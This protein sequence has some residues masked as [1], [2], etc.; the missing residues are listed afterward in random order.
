[1]SDTTAG[2][3][4]PESAAPEEDPGAGAQDRISAGVMTLYGLPAV[5]AGYMFMLISLYFLKYAT[6]VL[7]ISPAAMG[8]IF[9]VGRI[10]D[11][12]TDPVAGYL[13]DRTKTRFGRRRPWIVASALP[14]GGAF[15]LLW[16]PPPGELSETWRVLWV[17]GAVL[18]FY[19]GMTSF[20]VPHNSL[21]A[22]LSTSYH[23][24]T[25]VFGV[26]QIAWQIG[27]FV[28]LGL[29]YWLTTSDDPS[30]LASQ[31]AVTS[32]LVMVGLVVVMAVRMRERPEFQ[33]RGGENPFRAFRDVWRN[34]H[35]RLLL[36]V[37]FIES[38][39]GAVIGVLTIYF[40]EYVVETPTYTTA[41]IGA[42]F[43]ALTLAIPVWAPLSQRF[44][45]RRLWFLSMVGTA[46]GF[47]S[48]FLL[49]PG[50]WLI[51]VGIAAFLGIAGGCGGIVGPSIQADVI[52][53]DD[54]K[55][56]ERKE[57][58]YFAA[59]NFAFKSATGVMLG[60]TGFVLEYSG[61]QPNVEQ[62][63]SAKMAIRSLYAL[64]PLVCY[65][66]GALLFLRF[67]LGE[68]EYAEVRAA[69]DERKA[70]EGH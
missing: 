43:V 24:R 28:A 32:A 47:G 14:V 13:S 53:Y 21:G 66:I 41:Y 46:L 10:W 42:Y 29:M 11:A 54:Y 59:W 40:S 25:R 22:E 45:K 20:I 6:D 27:A 12:V 31:Q 57:G 52:D 34:P 48:T 65:G 70:R 68:E 55:T 17:A 36:F 50:E 7:L 44:G 3:L 64:F 8:T 56:G 60:L 37:F 23:Q 35:A 51:F 18:L 26:R 62:T 16:I 5:G 38:V 49:P 63:D 61:F 69:L 30:I 4:A 33:G 1:M 15:A 39:G 67:R 2:T 9:M 58:A 19:T